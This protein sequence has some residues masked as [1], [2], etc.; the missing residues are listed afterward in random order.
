[1]DSFN[2]RLTD[3]QWARLQP[4]FPKCIKRSRGKP[5]T[6]WRC[7]VN[8]IFLVLFTKIKWSALPVSPEFATKSAAHRWFVL[9]EKNGFLYQLITTLE[10]GSEKVFLPP[11][12]QRKPAL[13]QIEETNLI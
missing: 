8:S 4:L 2:E 7:V 5:H 9:W 6:P 12:R 1:M 13:I 10:V 3:S 11:R